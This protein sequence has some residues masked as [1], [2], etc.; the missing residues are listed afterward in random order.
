MTFRGELAFSSVAELDAALAEGRGALDDDPLFDEHAFVREGTKLR[1]NWHESA[2]AS[3][4]D[5]A[6]SF[7]GAIA[8]LA[9]GGR[10]MA[11][12]ASDTD[13]DQIEIIVPDEQNL[14]PEPGPYATS[15]DGEL[16][17]DAATFD[18]AL[19]DFREY[20]DLRATPLEIE[21][22]N[23]T[24]TIHQRITLH[25]KTWANECGWL[26]RLASRAAS[27]E[28]VAKI[29]HTLLPG[30]EVLQLRAGEEVPVW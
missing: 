29:N 14:E 24:V 8:E 16:R 17:F 6:V 2:P 19:R 22:T 10:V 15:F 28:I 30:G 12:F 20:A 11:V 18:E 5:G 4:W 25:R 27:G 9:S 7:I 26:Q 3:M 1:I 13:E 21:I 23:R